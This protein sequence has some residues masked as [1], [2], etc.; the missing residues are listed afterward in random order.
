MA[1]FQKLAQSIP[2]PVTAVIGVRRGS[3]H[4]QVCSTIFLPSELIINMIY[5]IE[6][7]LLL[8]T[9]YIILYSNI[10]GLFEVVPLEGV[11]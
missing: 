2:N 9:V 4:S 3:T 5:S 7:L 6:V 10:R 11:S 8:Y 1:F